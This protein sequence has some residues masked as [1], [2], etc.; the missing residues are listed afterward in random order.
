MVRASIV[1]I[2]ALAAAARAMPHTVEVNTNYVASSVPDYS[3]SVETPQYS[4]VESSV[5]S[6]EYSTVPEE[7]STPEETTEES[8]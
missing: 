6:P 1:S 4:T 3:T 7:S 2:F 5:S 8:S